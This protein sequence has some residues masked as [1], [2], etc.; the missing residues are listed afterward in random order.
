MTSVLATLVYYP[1]ARGA[2]VAEN[3]GAEVANLPLSAY[4]SLSFYT[5]RTDA[6]DRFGTRLEQR[7]TR[8]QIAAMMGAAGLRDVRFSETVPFWVAVGVRET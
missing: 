8:A 2:L 6:L 1:L 5:M 4:R 7:F 3:L